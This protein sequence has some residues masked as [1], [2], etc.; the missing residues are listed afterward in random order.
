MADIKVSNFLDFDGAEDFLEQET[1]GG[2]AFPPYLADFIRQNYS[3]YEE[4]QR[5]YNKVVD[6]QILC[7]SMFYQFAYGIVDAT[8]DIDTTEWSFYNQEYVRAFTTAIDLL[9]RVVPELQG[10][11]RSRDALKVLIDEYYNTTR[12]PSDEV[13]TKHTI[14]DCAVRTRRVISRDITSWQGAK[15]DDYVLQSL[16][17]VYAFLGIIINGEWRPHKN[18]KQSGLPRSLT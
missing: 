15:Q 11:E 18:V 9:M 10:T 1:F 3:L 8:N 17:V 7:R 16:H 13:N 12:E 6:A 5:K 4:E 14:T 2:G